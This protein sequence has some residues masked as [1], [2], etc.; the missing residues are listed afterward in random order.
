MDFSFLWEG[1]NKSSFIVNNAAYFLITFTYPATL[2]V[3]IIKRKY[4]TLS[5]NVVCNL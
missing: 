2:A 5:D 4:E 1:V 3:A